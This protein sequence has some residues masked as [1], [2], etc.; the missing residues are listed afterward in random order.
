MTRATTHAG[1]WDPGRWIVC[2][3]EIPAEAVDAAYAVFGGFGIASIAVYD[4]DAPPGAPRPAPGFVRVQAYT[5][6]VGLPEA[7]R[8]GDAFARAL[9]EKLGEAVDAYFAGAGAPR[10]GPRLP[11]VTVQPVVNDDWAHRWK[12]HFE[13]MT[14]GAGWLIVPPWHADAPVPPGRRR[15][16]VEPGMA[17][18]TGHH[19]S[20]RL[21]LET[22]EALLSPPTGAPFPVARML[23]VGCG[24]GVLATAALLLGAGRAFAFDTDPLAVAATADNARLN[25]VRFAAV[26]GRVSRGTRLVAAAGELATLSPPRGFGGPYDLV[27]ANILLDVLTALG[28]DLAAAV[29]PGGRLVAAGILDEQLDAL[30]AAWAPYPLRLLSVRHEDGWAAPLFARD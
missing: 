28:A 23:D 18:G 19:A 8:A 4:T 20:T 10:P 30:R 16:V 5:E 11:P 24:T 26:P 1:D 12:E 3:T 9:A 2:D 6:P 29:R 7:L 13:P 14:V 15:L 22:I 25:D 27:A 21:C 17:F